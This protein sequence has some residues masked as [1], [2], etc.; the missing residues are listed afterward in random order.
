MRRST[1]LVIDDH[2]LIVDTLTRRL[3]TLPETSEI[4]VVPFTNDRDAEAFVRKNADQI[5]GVIQDLNRPPLL[6]MQ[7]V[8]FL[9][10]VIEPLIPWARTAIL[11][12]Y[13]APQ[14]IAEFLQSAKYDV[15]FWSKLALAD[16]GEDVLREMLAWLLIPSDSDRSVSP[17]E[18][19]GAILTVL[20]PAWGDVCRYLATHPNSLHTMN[21]QLFER[22]V[23][24]IFRSYGCS[25]ELTSK[26]KDGGY[27]IIAIRRNLPTD[28]RILIEAKRFAPDRSVGVGIVRSLYG[29]LASTSASQLVLATSSHVTRD[30]KLEFARVIPWQLDFFER[31]RILAWCRETGAVESAGDFPV[32]SA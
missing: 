18:T 14:A 20:D 27:D 5:F 7:G 6:G 30:A 31:D 19:E 8:R 24:E 12:A 13:E 2:V 26:T 11:S 15:R 17:T 23:A 32:R 28:I 1:L 10:E 29:V 9:S 16:R 22:L 25:V 21:P 3:R 4:N